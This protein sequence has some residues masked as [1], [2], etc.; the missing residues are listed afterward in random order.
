MI[1]LVFDLTAAFSKGYDSR[2]YF[3]I[4]E[5]QCQG[6]LD[7]SFTTSVEYKSPFTSF[8]SHKELVP[9][10]SSHDAA[11]CS[12]YLPG[13]PLFFLFLYHSFSSSHLNLFK[14]NYYWTSN[15]HHNQFLLRALSLGLFCNTL[16]HHPTLK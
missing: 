4:I 14:I 2:Y 16:Y 1:R 12:R 15:N 9:A 13:Y 11:E 10:M 5:L 8:L 3:D 7:T 6:Y